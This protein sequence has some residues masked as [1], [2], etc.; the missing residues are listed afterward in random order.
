MS[1]L[2][3]L[4]VH[5]LWA[6]RGTG[7]LTLPWHLSCHEEIFLTCWKEGHWLPLGLRQQVWYRWE[8]HQAEGEAYCKGFLSGTGVRL[9]RD[10]CRGSS[11][12][13]LP[14]RYGHRCTEGDEDLASRLHLCL[15]E[16][17]CQYDVYMELPPGFA[18]QGEDD[19]DGIAPQVERSEG[20]QG[21]MK[22][23]FWSREGSRVMMKNASCCCSKLSMGWCRVRTIGSIYS[24]MCLPLSG[25]TNPRPTRVSGHV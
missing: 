20:E 16:Q 17:C 15:P 10:V 8:C 25:T 18:P 7:E 9:R 22:N 5:R 14:H 21:T 6:L 23:M 3:I 4:Y 11:T 19:K 12:W 2:S 24:T 13:I 1:D